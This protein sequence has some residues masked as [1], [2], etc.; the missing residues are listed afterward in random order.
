M[1]IYFLIAAALA[2]WTFSLIFSNER[3]KELR[4]ME[5]RIAESAPPE[6]SGH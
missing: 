2:V 4:D 1:N 6:Q 5:I 3:K